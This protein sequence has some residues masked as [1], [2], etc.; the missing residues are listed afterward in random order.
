V[1]DVYPVCVAQE[2]RRRP[3][4]SRTARSNGSALSRDRIIGKRAD[5]I[6]RPETTA[7]IERPDQAAQLA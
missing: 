6:F 3:L 5:E 7:S 1:L 4:Y 2:Y